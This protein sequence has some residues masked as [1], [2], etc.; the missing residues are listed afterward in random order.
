[1]LGI[2]NSFS[3]GIFTSFNL[4]QDNLQYYVLEIMLKN[5]LSQQTCQNFIQTSLQTNNLDVVKNLC[6]KYGYNI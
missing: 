3:S 1:M 2:A 4:L 5:K 6:T